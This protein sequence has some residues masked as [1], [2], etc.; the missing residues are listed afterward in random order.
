MNGTQITTVTSEMV[1]E[2]LALAK[3]NGD[4]LLADIC[5][6]TRTAGSSIDVTIYGRAERVFW[7]SDMALALCLD[8]INGA[9]IED[10]AF[11]TL[12]TKAA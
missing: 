8:I 7:T 2:L 12:T 11:A 4:S 3:S 9:D 1:R 5:Y 10:A 6:A